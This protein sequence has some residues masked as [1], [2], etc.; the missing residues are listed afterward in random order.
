M[1]VVKF[2]LPANLQDAIDLIN[3]SEPW[4]VW[5]DEH[6]QGINLVFGDQ[7]KFTARTREE[8]EAF[9]AGFFLATFYGNSLFQIRQKIAEGRLED[10][11]R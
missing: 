9:V 1:G 4:N 11:R 6:D 5:L 7:L 2:P 8:A 3:A 10:F